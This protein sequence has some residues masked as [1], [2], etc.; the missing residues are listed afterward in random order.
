MMFIEDSLLYK[1]SSCVGSDIENYRQLKREY[2]PYVYVCNANSCVDRLN[3]EGGRDLDSRLIQIAD[4]RKEQA[5][6]T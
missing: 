5:A 4:K 3:I 6:E 1:D 2:L